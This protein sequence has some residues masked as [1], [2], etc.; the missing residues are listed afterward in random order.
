MTVSR[1]K[2]KTKTT[3]TQFKSNTPFGGGGGGGGGGAPGGL[4]PL[5]A[6]K[7]HKTFYNLITIALL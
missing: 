3:I 5:D 2:V 7:K 4:H 1:M 6:F